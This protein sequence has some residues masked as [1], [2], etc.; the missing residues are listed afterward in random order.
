[1][2]LGPVETD[3]LAE[4]LGNEEALRFEPR[5]QHSHPEV[6]FGE[7]PL[8]GKASEGSCVER[9][10][11]SVISPRLKCS[12]NYTVGEIHAR[13]RREEGPAHLKQDAAGIFVFKVENAL[14]KLYRSMHG[15][16]RPAY[17]GAGAGADGALG[18]R[19]ARYLCA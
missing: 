18:E 12:K 9:H 7:V 3:H 17:K 19:R 15:E 2:H 16:G 1:M 11:R 8:I 13:K 4:S 10:P 14:L 6:C 5:L